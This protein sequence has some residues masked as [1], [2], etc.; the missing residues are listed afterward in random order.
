MAFRDHLLLGEIRGSLVLLGEAAR[1]FAS[2]KMWPSHR[3]RSAACVAASF[4]GTGPLG[5]SATV[6]R[7]DKDSSEAQ[8]ED[9]RTVCTDFMDFTSTISNRGFLLRVT[10]AGAL[11][12]PPQR[13]RFPN[14]I[15]SAMPISG[16]G[17]RSSMTLRRGQETPPRTSR[18]SQSREL[19]AQ[20]QPRGM[21]R[22]LDLVVRRLGLQLP[23]EPGALV[24]ALEQRELRVPLQADRLFRVLAEIGPARQHRVWCAVEI[25]ARGGAEAFRVLPEDGFAC[26]EHVMLG[27]RTIS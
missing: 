20:D 7:P 18:N 2:P 4:A 26:G 10:E 22:Q 12:F 13:G 3:S 23:G 9:M 17:L 21:A 14:C 8:S 5:A 16:L 19:P 1:D 11:R 15:S 6:A 25:H 27:E 24:Q